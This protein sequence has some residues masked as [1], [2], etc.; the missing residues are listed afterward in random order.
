MVA[1]G[2]INAETAWMFRLPS[3]TTRRLPTAASRARAL[4][5]EQIFECLQE[6]EQTKKDKG[7]AREINTKEREKTREQRD[8]VFVYLTQH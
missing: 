4:T 1:A 8:R 6:A 5:S 7:E 2:V 3:I